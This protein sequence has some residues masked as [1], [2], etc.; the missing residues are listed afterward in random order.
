MVNVFIIC[1]EDNRAVTFFGIFTLSLWL[2]HYRPKLVLYRNQSIDLL[3]KS[4]DWVSIWWLGEVTLT[5]NRLNIKT[6][7]MLIHFICCCRKNRFQVEWNMVYGILISFLLGK[8]RNTLWKKISFSSYLNL[9]LLES[10]KFVNVC[11][12]T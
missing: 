1:S 5:F 7:S 10:T 2:T 11:P 9:M 8:Y 12:Q 6:L 3:C 4:I